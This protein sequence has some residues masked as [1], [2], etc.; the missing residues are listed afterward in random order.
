VTLFSSP[1]SVGIIVTVEA[2]GLG[3]AKNAEGEEEGVEGKTLRAYM[4]ASGLLAGVKRRVLEICDKLEAERR[5]T[6]VGQCVGRVV[7][8]LGA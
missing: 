7:G 2:D 4:V 8:R 5:Q 6:K 3:G 1:T